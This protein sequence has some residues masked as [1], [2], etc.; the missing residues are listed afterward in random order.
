M[1]QRVAI[2]GS[3]IAG[4]C[5]AW[6]LKKDHEVTLFERH[7][8]LG[9]DAFSIDLP[10]RTGVQ[11]IDVPMRVVYE[12]YYPN[13][14]SLYREAGI[15]LE[16]LEYS[17][18][19]TRLGG[20]TYFSYRNLRLGPYALPMLSGWRSM[21]RL[22]T[23]HIV[24]DALRFFANV[25]RD[26][27]SGKAE[28]L[29]LEGYLQTRKFSAA[30]V[31]GF[32]VPALAG[33]CTCTYAAVRSCPAGVVLDYF[34][35]G[36]FNVPVK[37][38]LHG[39]QDVVTRLSAAVQHIRLG[40][41]VDKV[42]TTAAG[43][44]VSVGGVDQHFDHVLIAAQANHALRML[45]S[46]PQERDVLSSFTY[47]PSTVLMHSDARLAPPNRALWRPV[48]FILAPSAEMPMATIWMNTVHRKLGGEDVFQTWSPVIEPD[49]AHVFS[50]V[51][52]ERP[53]VNEASVQG[54]AKLEALHAMPGRRIWFVGAYPSPGVPL[55]ESAVSSGLTV[56]KWIS[57]RS[58]MTSVS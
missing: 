34:A 35:H 22:E 42:T 17:G 1:T 20:P 40:Y 8:V 23:V 12:A 28:G 54:I 44:T 46:T 2:I 14:I 30:F 6:A 3:G 10:T 52:V 45:Q 18:S 57:K 56:A 32:L 55:L 58:A 53:V 16:P 5:A 31:D 36:L 21:R 33:I 4:L 47:Q 37:R 38:V 26:L 51:A 13:V 39:T 41:A 19:F 15:E 29:T 7:P 43:A 9:M 24:T 50:R 25:A 49:P 48:N 27:R 11:R